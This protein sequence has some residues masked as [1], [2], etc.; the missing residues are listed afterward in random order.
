[1]QIQNI[2]QTYQKDALP[3]VDQ[4][5]SKLDQQIKWF[6][7]AF[8]ARNYD[9]IVLESIGL[10]RAINQPII[11]GKAPLYQAILNIDTDVATFL[12]HHPATDLNAP[13]TE[14]GDTVLWFLLYAFNN[15]DRWYKKLFLAGRGYTSNLLQAL[16]LRTDFNPNER[17]NNGM[18]PLSY[19]IQTESFKDKM[20]V[21][22]IQTLLALGT[23]AH[24]KN[25]N[26]ESL[27][28]QVR[29]SFWFHSMEGQEIYKLLQKSQ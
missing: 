10:G 1:M 13:I 12:L 26:K 5:I 20:D 11:N 22:I 9:E 17:S 6:A 8:F 27:I 4:P 15:D 25:E 2:L 7:E 29:K 16:M 24:E 14:E 28:E 23:D 3:E 18:T 19:L 21:K